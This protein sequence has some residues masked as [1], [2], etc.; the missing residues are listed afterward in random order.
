ML[1]PEHVGYA[2]L[3]LLASKAP[4]GGKLLQ[5]RQLR[6]C[7]AHGSRNASL[8]SREQLLALDDDERPLQIAHLRTQPCGAHGGKLALE[9]LHGATLGRVFERL[10]A[11]L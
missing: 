1:A 4:V 10:F 3:Q 2:I 8:L 11:S 5:L 9:L 6:L 7:L